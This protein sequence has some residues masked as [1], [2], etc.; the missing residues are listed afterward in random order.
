[1]NEVKHTVTI[2]VRQEAW[3][4]FERICEIDMHHRNQPGPQLSYYLALMAGIAPPLRNLPGFHEG[5]EDPF[6][7]EEYRLQKIEHR[8]YKLFSEDIRP[9]PGGVIPFPDKTERNRILT[10]Q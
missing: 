5:S 6:W 8:L 7:K 9:A 4:M 2:S 10:L 1:M 3:L